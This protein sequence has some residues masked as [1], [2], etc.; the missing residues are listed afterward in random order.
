MGANEFIG[1][2]ELSWANDLLSFSCSGVDP[3]PTECSVAPLPTTH[4]MVTRSKSGIFVP[5]K[6]YAMVAAA[7]NLSPVPKTIHAALADTKLAHCNGGR[8]CC[9]AC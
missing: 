4:H 6:K 5:N 9:P 2:N 1:A 8:I 7:D 3:V